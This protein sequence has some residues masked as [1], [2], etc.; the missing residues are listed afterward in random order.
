MR[1]FIRTITSSTISCIS[2]GCVR[3][4]AI[5]SRDDLAMR[6]RAF[7]AVVVH[8]VGKHVPPVVTNAAAAAGA[9]PAAGPQRNRLGWQQPTLVNAG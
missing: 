6:L 4:F 9:Y 3:V 7:F 8:V 5:D 2:Q 1:T